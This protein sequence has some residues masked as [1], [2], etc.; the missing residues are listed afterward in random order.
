MRI[1]E[2]FSD[3]KERTHVKAGE[4]VFKEGQHGDLM[5]VLLRG[6][7]DIFVAGH[8]IGTFEAVEI[9]GEMAVIDP[10]PRSA[11]VIAK[12]DCQFVTLNQKRFILLTEHKPDFAIH[13][14][15]VLVERIRWLNMAAQTPAQKVG[16]PEEAIS[17]PGSY[18]NL[19]GDAAESLENKDAVLV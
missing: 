7:V 1:E 10:G 11:T 18:D 8:L 2:C 15:R 13:V 19:D 12:T 17:Q 4:P 9:I 14:M 5:Y 16:A 3:A 6:V